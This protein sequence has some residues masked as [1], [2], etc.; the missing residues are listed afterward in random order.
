MANGAFL[1][2][3]TVLAISGVLPTARVRFVAPLLKLLLEVDAQVCHQ[4]MEA[5]IK[6]MPPGAAVL[7]ASRPPVAPPARPPHA[8]LPALSLTC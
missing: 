5:A 1:T 7:P 6:E 3:Q 2:K 8:F 4:W